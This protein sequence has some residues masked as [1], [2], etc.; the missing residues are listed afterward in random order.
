M[1]TDFMERMKMACV[2]LYVFAIEIVLVL[3]TENQPPNI[4]GTSQEG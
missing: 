3:L 4:H 2:Q 1:S